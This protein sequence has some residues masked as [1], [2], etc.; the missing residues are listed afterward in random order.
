MYKK[1]KD[2]RIEIR[3]FKVDTFFMKAVGLYGL[4][5]SIQMWLHVIETSFNFIVLFKN[6][7]ALEDDSSDLM[8]CIFTKLSQTVCLIN[9]HILICL[10]AK[11][12]VILCK[13]LWFNDVLGHFYIKFNFVTY[14]F[15]KL[16]P[17]SNF[18]RLVN[19][20]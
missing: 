8:N 12:K 5:K 1:V 9:T 16:Y 14:L 4:W 18:H 3:I 20:L 19:H 17:S 6:Y 7:Q 10:Y 13:N 2:I 15:Q 11:Y